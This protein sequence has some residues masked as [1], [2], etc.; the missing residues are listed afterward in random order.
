MSLIDLTA[1]AVFL[2]VWLFYE[3]L[4]TRLTGGR[5]SLNV[6][7][8][9]IRAGWM[10]ALVARESRLMDSQFLGHTINSASFFGS[11]NMI[12][13]AALG[14]F[15]F[16]GDKNLQGLEHLAIVRSGPVWLLEFKVA[17]MLLTLARGML[18]F[19]WAIRQLNYCL[20]AIGS[21]PENLDAGGRNKWALALTSMLNPALK[22]FSRGVRAYY[23]SLAA[24]GW[25]FG[26]LALIATTIGAAGLLAW[27]Q[28][29]SQAALGIASVNSL[30]AKETG[31]H[32]AA[33]DQT[34][35]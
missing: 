15:M 25:F 9:D 7:M 11:A 18:D 1:F 10:R 24:A 2:F 27:R 19:V 4:L 22:T 13:I 30:L 20:A 29:H 16:G 5:G 23:F 8:T 34:P 32:E 21:Y 31:S 28:T 17:L 26:P 3:P 14:G 33:P 12:A 6:H 35:V